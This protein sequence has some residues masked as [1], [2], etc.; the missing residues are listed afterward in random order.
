VHEGLLYQPVQQF[1]GIFCLKNILKV[2]G[3]ALFTHT[4][5]A[6]EQMEI[7]VAQNHFDRRSMGIK[8]AQGS[9]IVGASVYE[10]TDRPQL[11]VF[12]VKLHLSK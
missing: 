11:V 2:I 1:V 9:D 10:I 6:G 4:C 7:M 12:G 8:P 5:M 3:P